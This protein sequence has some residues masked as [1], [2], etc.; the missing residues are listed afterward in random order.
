MRKETILLL[1]I[2]IAL[3]VTAIPTKADTVVHIEWD[4][5]NPDIEVT[6]IG[7]ASSTYPHDYSVSWARVSGSGEAARGRIEVTND[8]GGLG[9]KMAWQEAEFAGGDYEAEVG[10]SYEDFTDNT[11]F[12]A[13][14]FEVQNAEEASIEQWV[15]SRATHRILEG[16]QVFT[17]TDADVVTAGSISRKTWDW[18]T[19]QEINYMGRAH[20]DVFGSQGLWNRHWQYDNVEYGMGFGAGIEGTE[21]ETVF[22]FEIT[23]PSAWLTYDPGTLHTVVVGFEFSAFGESHTWEELPDPNDPLDENFDW[24][25][26]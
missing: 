16:F 26:P 22:I 19:E 2:T 25:E 11:L 6:M 20:G 9:L 3:L 8:F 15:S 4:S 1:G 7:A 5:P 17:A 10:T 21:G 13:H 23:T 24:I 12:A 18:N 14:S